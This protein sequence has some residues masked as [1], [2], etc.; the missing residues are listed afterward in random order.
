MQINRTLLGATAAAALIALAGGAYAADPEPGTVAP[1]AAG[2]PSMSNPSMSNPSTSAPPEVIAPAPA[3][4]LGAKPAKPPSSIVGKD[5]VS[6][7]GDK[8]GSV[9]KIDGDRVIVSV[10]GFLGIG[11]HDVALSWSQLSPNDT[12]DK[13]QLVTALSKEELKAMP[14]YGAT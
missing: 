9:T 2:S 12:G 10:G 8:I 5:V 7:A 11:S 1:P 13:Q 4:R 14:E 3:D 6:A